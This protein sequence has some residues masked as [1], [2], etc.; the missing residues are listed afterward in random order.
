VPRFRP[1]QGEAGVPGYRLTARYN[2]PLGIAGVA[3][4]SGFWGV[5]IST[6][7]FLALGK[8]Y[9]RV[10]IG[11]A[12]PKVDP[13]IEHW[14]LLIPVFGPFIGMKTTRPSPASVVG[15][16]VLG[17]GQLAGAG[18]LIGSLVW[19]EKVW[20]RDDLGLTVLPWLSPQATGVSIGGAL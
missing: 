10:C 7:L 17:A 12:C 3:T 18:M 20:K 6:S 11:A 4:F 15:L 1:Y 13:G 14:A 9:K 2:R 5:S 16:G 8:S 19:P